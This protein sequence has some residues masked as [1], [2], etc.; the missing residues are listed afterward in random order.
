MRAK[1]QKSI[2]GATGLY[3]PLMYQTTT[4]WYQTNRA[5]VLRIA[6]SLI[7]FDILP[8]NMIWNFFLRSFLNPMEELCRIYVSRKWFPAG[9]NW[10]SRR[11]ILMLR[12]SKIFFD[13][14][15][16]GTIYRSLKFY[17]GFFLMKKKIMYQK[18]SKCAW[19]VHLKISILSQHKLI[20][21]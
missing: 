2:F 20:I 21:S 4:F 10:R 15:P 16:P 19:C 14:H 7:K 6:Y 8:R 18:L 1:H 11:Y 17:N 5:R 13:L 12:P 3:P 9:Q